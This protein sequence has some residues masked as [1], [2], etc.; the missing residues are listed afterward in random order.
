M[1]LFTGDKNR[2]FLDPPNAIV[3]HNDSRMNPDFRVITI[4]FI[5]RENDTGRQFPAISLISPITP[6][7]S[8]V[9][10]VIRKR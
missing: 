10:M 7:Q 2:R 6:A 1:N 9:Q 5:G 8:I 4:L 3:H